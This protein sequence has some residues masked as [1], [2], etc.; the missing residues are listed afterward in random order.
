MIKRIRN[1][2]IIFL[3][4]LF[5]MSCTLSVSIL[6][7]SAA[8]KK[9]SIEIHYKG[10]TDSQGEVDFS[11]ATFT[12]FQIQSAENGELVWNEEFVSAG[13][14]LKDTSAGAREKQAEKLFDYAKKNNITGTIQET[15]TVGY[16]SFLNLDEGI[17]LLAQI[18]TVDSGTEQFESAPFLIEVPSEIS[19]RF[20]YNVETEPK[21]EWVSKKEPP[22]V[23]NQPG[24]TPEKTPGKKE[25][26]S[27][28]PIR[29]MI[30]KV[31]T[32]DE[33]TFVMWICVACAGLGIMIVIS[34]KRNK[35]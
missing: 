31:K 11:G 6:Q 2:R 33:T 4:I 18:G 12:L 13:I 28:N 29:D 3:Y 5:L 17:Y 19:G 7:V 21:A 23:P 22:V 1:T 26:V 25:P 8:T 32:G 20:E 34:R 14:S 35:E 15:N 16:T 9:G 24:D 30:D 27:S 10:R